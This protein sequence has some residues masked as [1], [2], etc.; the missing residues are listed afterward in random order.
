M[1]L[2]KT[3]IK[4]LEN[5]ETFE[6]NYRKVL[7]HRVN[8][9]IRAFRH[10][11]YLMRSLGLVTENCNRVTENCNHEISSNQAALPN[12]SGGSGAPAGIRTRVFGSKGRNT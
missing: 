1:M 8:R 9:K 12:L 3:E 7:K 10:E 11:L 2:S 5:P 6:P 4:F